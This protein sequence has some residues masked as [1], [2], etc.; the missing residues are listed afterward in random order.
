ML[1]TIL[2]FCAMF[3]AVGTANAEPLK[4]TDTQMD[5]VTAGDLGLPSDMI[6]FEGFGTQGNQGG[7]HPNFGRSD[8][9][10]E[11]TTGHG[12]S[13]GGTGNE[14]PWSATV[15]SPQISFCAG[16]ECP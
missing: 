3:M 7:F 13:V 11:A 9:A 2:I 10:F 15:V 1:R 14:G 5:M 8:T 16:G 4:L 12:P 6:I